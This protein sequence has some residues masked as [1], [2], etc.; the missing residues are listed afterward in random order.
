MC[1]FSLAKTIIKHIDKYRKHC[2]WRG[3]DINNKKLPKAAWPMVCIPKEEGGL[4]VHNLKTQNDSLLLKHL[5]KFFNRANV[6]WV[7]LV[8]NRYYADGKLP[9]LTANLR[10]SF[11][12]RD[13]LKL[14]DSYKGFAMISVQDGKSCFFWLDLWNGQTLQQTFP[15]LF[16]YC[17]D[18][19]ISV[20]TVKSTPTAITLF[21][22]PLSTEAYE[23][24]LQLDTLIQNLQITTDSDKWIYT[25]GSG[26]FS[27]QKAY[28]S[29]MGSSPVHPIYKWLWK[30]AC[31]KK[32]KFFF[33]LVLKDRLSTRELLRRKS[34]SLPDYNCVLCT[35]NVEES[36]HHLLLDCPF[37]MASRNILTCLR[38]T[39]LHTCRS[40]RLSS[41]SFSCHSSWK[42]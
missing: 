16:S 5:D 7:H 41:F 18:D 11:W 30:L 37:A 39:P 36:L 26:L 40:L 23:Q 1:T 29:L 28:K 2:L 19:K 22:L 15:E 35:H 12:W 38:Q 31:Q 10:G 8:W 33:W 20:S 13:I 21:H 17:K 6:P 32:R 27:S 3:S 42:S 24:F 14:L 25:W 9:I 4:G 34:I